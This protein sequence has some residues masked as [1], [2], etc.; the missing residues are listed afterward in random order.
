MVSDSKVADNLTSDL[1]YFTCNVTVYRKKEIKRS[2]PNYSK[3]DWETIRLYLVTMVR[4]IFF[5]MLTVILC[6]TL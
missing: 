5:V 1:S 6:V 2:V 4:K 3:V